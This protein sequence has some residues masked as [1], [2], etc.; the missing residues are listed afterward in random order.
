MP[1]AFSGNSVATDVQKEGRTTAAKI[2]CRGLAPGEEA[3]YLQFA[4]QAFGRDWPQADPLFLRW[5]YQENP[6]TRGIARDLLVLM[7]NGRVVGAHHRMRLPWLLNGKPCIVPS[8][9]DLSVLPAYRKVASEQRLTPPGLRIMLAALEEETHV[10]LFGLVEVVDQ[11]YD[12]LRV[13]AVKLFWLEKIRSRIHA[14][15]QLATSR[16]GLKPHKVAPIERQTTRAGDCEIIR[17][18]SPHDDEIS[19]ALSLKPQAQ[20]YPD[21]DLASYRWRFFHELGPRNVLFLVRRKSETVARA[22]VSLGLKK[23][24]LLGRIVDLVFKDGDC[25]PHPVA[26]IDRTFDE[27]RVPVSLAVAS[28][29]DVAN[30]LRAAGWRDRKQNVGAR[31]YS[32][33][34]AELPQDLWLTG[35]AWDFGCDVK[36]GD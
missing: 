26:A 5:L 10:G 19:E 9:H 30:A 32:T 18:P 24:V 23:G 20:S 14:G 4:G 21:W 15:L 1:T 34:G 16:V 36:S 22:V 35:G 17:I 6:N 12:R 27:L 25:L 8:V 29:Q 7:D 33:L 11:I 2:E 13:P 28:S 3:A 31:W